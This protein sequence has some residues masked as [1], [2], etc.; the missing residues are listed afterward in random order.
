MKVSYIRDPDL[1]VKLFIIGRNYCLRWDY[2]YCHISE[3][4]GD[5][6]WLDSAYEKAGSMEYGPKPGDETD[7]AK[8][9]VCTYDGW[10]RLAAVYKDNDSDGVR[11]STSGSGGD[12]Q[13]VLIAE[14]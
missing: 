2:G 12:A 14:Y 3:G 4:G 7:A 9:L 10:N 13:D 5:P 6:V 8:A 11:P 1:D